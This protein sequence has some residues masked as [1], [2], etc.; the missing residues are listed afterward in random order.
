MT[1][2]AI[3]ARCV[4]YEIAT[5]I[6]TWGLNKTSGGPSTSPTSCS[7]RHWPRGTLISAILLLFRAEVA[8]VDQSIAEA[9]TIFACSA[10]AVSADPH[11]PAVGAF[12]VLP[13]PNERGPLWVNFR[14]PCSWTSSRST[15]I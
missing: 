13:Y 11:G 3:G 4:T 15:R 6:G 9:M 12:W 10:G 2:L 14:S 5:G 8:D 1:A 7:D